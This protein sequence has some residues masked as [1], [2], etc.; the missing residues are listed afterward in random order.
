M[1]YRG[2]PRRESALQSHRRS[3]SVPTKGLSMKRRQFAA[4][5]VGAAG[6]APLKALGQPTSQRLPVVGW[7][8]ALQVRPNPIGDEI[9]AELG[10]LGWVNGKNVTYEVRGP[11]SDLSLLP[12]MAA[13]L[14]AL[15]V[16]LILAGSPLSA[17]AAQGATKTIP[18]VALADD[19]QARGLVSNIARPSG[20]TTGVS[21]F[22]SELDA[23]RLALL[24][25][26]VPSARRV[27]V[28]TA[29][30]A[31]PTMLQLQVA[32]RELKIGRA[33]CRERV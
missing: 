1:N 12:R 26:L 22:A 28:L 33:S 8:Q 25:E 23:K 3:S 7:L 14:A 15:P 24:V 11:P 2:S 30:K 16:T 5:L 6:S 20:N 29:S 19:M 27:A 18:I 31:D 32:A 4:M 21:I 13:E 10:R 17:A 9:A